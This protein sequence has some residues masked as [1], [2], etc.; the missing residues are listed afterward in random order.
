MKAPYSNLTCWFWKSLMA[1]KTVS[2]YY[3]PEEKY[4]LYA[5]FGISSQKKHSN[6]CIWFSHG[7]IYNAYGIINPTDTGIKA[8]QNRQCWIV[9]VQNTQWFFPIFTGYLSFLKYFLILCDFT[10]LWRCGLWY[11]DNLYL[12]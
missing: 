10:R 9:S 6:T 1:H 5:H 7:Y 11:S 12:P 3:L 4:Y 8:V 2:L